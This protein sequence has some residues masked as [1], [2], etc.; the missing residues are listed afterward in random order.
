MKR[1]MSVAGA[2]YPAT[3]EET[4]GMIAEFNEVLD[5]KLEENTLPDLSPRAIVAPHAGYIYS[6]FTA[7]IAYRVAAQRRRTDRVIVIGPSHRVGFAGISGSFFESYETP[8]GDLPIDRLYL[9]RLA[10]RFGVGFLEEAHYEHSTEVQMPFVRHY[11]GEIPVIEC[12]YSEP[13]RTVFENMVRFLLEDSANLVVISTDLSH[14][15]SEE[16]AGRR[17]GICI[18]ALFELDPKILQE[19]CQACGIIGLEA[20]IAAARRLG[21]RS[22]ILNYRTSAEVT[23][24]RGNVVGYLGAAIF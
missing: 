3:C 9:N 20:L 24:E 2:F 8:C 17:D 19:G 5:Q 6:G 18:R 16:E 13:D 4:E 22:Q 21:L 14:Y 7:N 11:F 1:G 12:I 23:G 15:Y 10:D